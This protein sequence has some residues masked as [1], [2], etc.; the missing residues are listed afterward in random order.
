MS[1]VA[2]LTL[3]DEGLGVFHS[4]ERGSWIGGNGLGEVVHKKNC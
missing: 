4:N 1:W 3:Y 2:A